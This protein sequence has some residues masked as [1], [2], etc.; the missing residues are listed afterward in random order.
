MLR[1]LRARLRQGHRTLAFPA[2]EPSLPAA[3]RGRPEVDGSRCVDGCDACARACPTEAI[4]V[5]GGSL[6]LDLG[7]CVFCG[8]CETSCPAGAVRFTPDYRMAVRRREDLVVGDGEY[9]LAAA[10]D[11][12]ARGLF[13][14]SF[15]LRQVSAGGSGAE[16]ADANV[17]TTVV[18]DLARFGV[19]FVASP[20]HADGLLVTG[21]VSASMRGPLLRTWEAVPAPRLV[22]A[23]GASAISGGPWRGSR[24]VEGGV[25]RVLPVDLY[26]P[27]FPPHPLTILDGILRLLGRLGEEP[28]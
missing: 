27:G 17:L 15:R 19:D 13:G 26:V 6:R 8:E 16:E 23:V 11:R 7:R 1:L 12:T 20:R 3:F 18:F 14:R 21:P 10:L 5:Q 28:R 4:E 9:R 24:E 25:D 22:I 2:A